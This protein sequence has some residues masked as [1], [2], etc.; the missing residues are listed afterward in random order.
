MDGREK[1]Q[2]EVLK[3]E[4]YVYDLDKAIFDLD[5]QIELVTS[6]ADTMDYLVS[7][8]SGLLCAALDIL[9]VGDFDLKRGRAIAS[10]Q[11]D[12]LVKKTAK[13][14]GCSDDSLESSVR[15][16]EKMFPL[17][18]DGNTPN[19]G[20]GLQHHLRDFAHHPTPVGLCFSLLTQ[21][22]YKAY[23]TDVN[24][25]F[26]IVDVPE[27]KRIFIG[28]DIPT[29][30]FFGTVYWFFHLV[31]DMAGSSSTVGG[32]GG[33]GIPGPLLSLAKELS[34]L[35]FFQN[36]K[37][38]DNTLS[39]F[40][41]KLFN[42]TLFAKRGTDGKIL[43]DTV[44]R[45]DLR[46]ELGLGI[47]L[48]RQ[49]VPVIAN[50]CIVRAFYFIR[51]L[52]A[53]MKGK[54]IH[55][56][57]QM[58]QVDWNTVKPANNPTIDR[59]LLIATGVF[60]SVDIG[61]AIVTQK[62]WVAVNYVG[63]GRF[64]VAIGKDVAWYLR[65][66]DLRQLKKMYETIERFAYRKLDNKIY[67]RIGEGM[68]I[69]RFGLTL[70]Q[71]EILYNIELLKVRNDIEQT[72]DLFNTEG[73]KA[74]K[75]EWLSE[76]QKYMETGFQGFMQMEGAKLHWYTE[77]ELERRIR[78]NRPN[79]VWFRLVLLEAMLFK[80]YYPLSVEKDKNDKAVPSKKYNRLNFDKGKG[81]AYLNKQFAEKICA[82]KF[83]KRLRKC[84]DDAIWELNET[85]KTL[86]TSLSITAITTLV[87]AI[88]AG[89]FA[90]AIAVALVGS[91]FAGLSGAA[92]TSACLAYLGGGAI[93][94][95]GAGMAGG[96]M[97]IVGGGAI[98]G[99]GAG[100]GAGGIVGM[101]SMNSKQATIAQSARLIVVTREI[102][103]NDEHDIAYSNSILEKYVRNIAD[104][105]KSLVDFRHEKDSANGKKKKEL[106]GKIKRMEETV[107]AMK[108]AEKILRKF[109]SSF[110]I[111][112]DNAT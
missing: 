66:R 102:F 110:K 35:P 101:A 62:Y 40:L 26:I 88:T 20:G 22:T 73:I 68:D 15:Y 100:A 17:P 47:E 3:D 36:M 106:E 51:R 74:L 97:A 93:A 90:P 18:S 27:N 7:I 58:S 6:H 49:A 42:G 64:A 32:S 60:T 85:L 87:V 4:P 107:K 11:V 25:R 56:I 105:E 39:Q 34:A 8:A 54:N 72:W 70:E 77:T 55:A 48:G 61:E 99:I 46:G 95:G 44:V 30:I 80:P 75:R 98:L 89:M 2:V 21:F 86:L 111:G 24:G 108:I 12:G 41:S 94:A 13:L 104:L 19:F 59:M 79:D 14:L 43:K 81:D 50:D 45:F 69:D 16:L 37:V 52:A 10:D 53:E 84:Y 67:E 112:L 91:N 78:N 96:T 65:A 76:W 57:D 83:I 103:L 109:I 92:L 1:M 31:S 71:T 28:Q 38:G 33:T 5:N 63:V 82:D 9:W 23:G 29:K